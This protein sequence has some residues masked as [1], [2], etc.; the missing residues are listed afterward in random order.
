M[1]PSVAAVPGFTAE[2]DL[3][4]A[5]IEDP[6]LQEGLAWGKPRRGHPEGSVGAHVADL[7][8]TIDRWGETGK[9]REELRLLA[10]VHDSLKNR[11]QNW[12]PKTGENHHA[13]RARRF[14]ERYV[15]DERLL[16]TIE[17]HD[18]PYDLWRKMRRRGHLDE[19][20]FTEMLD[21]IPDLDLF[22]RFVELDG[23]TEGK[24]H[25]P[26]R[27]LKA[28]LAQRG[29]F[30]GPVRER[31]HRRLT[32]RAAELRRGVGRFPCPYGREKRPPRQRVRT[33][34]TAGR[35]WRP[36]RCPQCCR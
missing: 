12:R 6:V 10:L 26:I 13:M 11:V 35:G 14:A 22:L 20:A 4:R 31:Q 5:L 8:A 18:R 9:R 25:E 17:Q 3:E 2:T 15:D 34:R 21:R 33:A 19:H 32:S 1:V 7:L 23:S 24:N 29:A 36:G 28:E 27:W 30:E 16:A